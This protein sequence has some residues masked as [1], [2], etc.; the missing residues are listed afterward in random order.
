GR[1]SLLL[2]SMATAFLMRIECSMAASGLSFKAGV[3]DGLP[4]RYHEPTLAEGSLAPLIIFLHGAG[5][6]GADDG[7]Q[8][9]YP[10]FT[11]PGGLFSEAPLFVLAPQVA[12]NDKWI[13]VEKWGQPTYN[14]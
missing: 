11:A 10:F 7:K 6:R 12:A 5:E 1:R 14:F 3:K 4:Y 2:L 9:S 8:V 13:A